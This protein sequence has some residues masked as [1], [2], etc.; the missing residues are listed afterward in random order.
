MEKRTVKRIPELRNG[1]NS[2]KGEGSTEMTRAPGG[3]RKYPGK[4]EKGE[5]TAALIH[6]KRDYHQYRERET[7]ERCNGGKV[8]LRRNLREGK[9]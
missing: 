8:R 9:K 7:H 3:G 1:D 5:K 4:R 2:G 6:A